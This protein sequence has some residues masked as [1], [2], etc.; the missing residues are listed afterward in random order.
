MRIGV[1]IIVFSLLLLGSCRDET[2]IIGDQ[3]F[4]NGKYEE[5]IEAIM[6]T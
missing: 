1:F 6:N 2:S 5:A 4:E 3:L